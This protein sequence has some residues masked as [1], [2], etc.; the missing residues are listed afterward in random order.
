MIIGLCMNLTHW[1]R[2]GVFLMT[3]VLS[4]VVVFPL[5][6]VVRAIGN[7]GGEQWKE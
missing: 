5:Y 1:N 3:A 4:A 7:I 6:P 2:L